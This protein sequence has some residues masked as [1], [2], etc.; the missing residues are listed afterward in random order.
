[1][2][3]LYACCTCVLYV[4]VL[5]ERFSKNV[6]CFV[7]MRRHVFYLKFFVCVMRY[8]SKSIKN[9]HTHT[10]THTKHVTNFVMQHIGWRRSIGSPKVQVRIRKR[11]TKCRALL[12][13]MTYE[14]KASYEFLPPYITH[15]APH[16]GQHTLRLCHPIYVVFATLYSSLP[17]YICLCHPI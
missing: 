7:C 14:D 17:P 8:I 6:T 10:H 12:R 5:C 11:A 1:M 9:R 3:V 16:I 4:C 2:C 13:K 15:N